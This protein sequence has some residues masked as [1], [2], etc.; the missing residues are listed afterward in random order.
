MLWRNNITDANPAADRNLGLSIDQMQRRDSLD[1]L[2]KAIYKDGSDFPGESHP[3]MVA[4]K[5]R[6]K[7][8]QCDNRGFSASK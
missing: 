8:K 4:L 5:S 7:D 6:K 1:P 3:V 2:W